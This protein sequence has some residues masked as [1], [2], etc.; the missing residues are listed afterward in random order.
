MI[1]LEAINSENVWK[2]C[3]LK[4]AT[5]QLDF[6]AT[7][8]QSIIEAYTTIIRNKIALPFAIKYNDTIVGFCMIGYDTIDD[9]DPKIAADSYFLWRFM[10]DEN[11]QGK[12]YGK[13]A[14]DVIIDY[15]KTRPS[16]PAQSCW[17]SYEP[18]NE[19][20]RHLYSTFGFIETGEICS[21]EIVS[22]ISL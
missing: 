5:N 4:V 17:L 1:H 19:G 3:N 12:G 18:E 9:E 20:A 8:Q 13:Q 22:V 15:I 14:L 7:N 11:Y 2:V 16:G 21:D 10:I 6:V